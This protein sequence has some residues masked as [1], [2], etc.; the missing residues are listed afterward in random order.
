M[1]SQLFMQMQ[2]PFGC[3]CA[4]NIVLS[5]TVVL[6]MIK[7][8]KSTDV[9]VRTRPCARYVYTGNDTV[10]IREW[11]EWTTCASNPPPVRLPVGVHLGQMLVRNG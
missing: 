7:T 3:V 6:V 9:R 5:E 2:S 1:K 8:Q 11:M 10:T 4:D